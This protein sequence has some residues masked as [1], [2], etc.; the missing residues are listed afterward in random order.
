[1]NPVTE[2]ASPDME[3]LLNR[4]RP[5]VRAQHAYR[6][7]TDVTSGAKLD[8]NESP[9]GLPANVRS[10][11]LELVESIDWHRYPDDRPHRLVAALEK[12]FQLQEGSVIVGRG[13]NELTQ[14]I[15]LT[16]VTPGAKV[17][18]PDPMFALFKAVVAMHGGEAVQVPPENDL[19]HSP[20]R[21][22]QAAQEADAALVIVTTP[23]NP[24]GQTID[25]EGLKHLAGSVPGFLLIDEAY[26]EF[27]GSRPA[28]DLIASYP[29]VLVMRTFSKALGMAGLRIGY[30]AGTPQVIAEVEKARLPFLVD[31]LSEE[32]ALL[33]MDQDET[34]EERVTELGEARRSLETTIGALPGAR[35]IPG[36]ANFFLLATPIAPSALRRELAARGV[37]IRDVSSYTHLSDFVRISVGTESENR[38]LVIALQAVLRDA[39]SRPEAL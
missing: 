34:I 22:A 13:S 19:R 38:A 11:M 26:H 36:S 27:F 28:T 5:S 39:A 9:F 17:V 23:N 1:M 12:R 35:V 20:E 4:I 18:L 32:A 2:P 7:A 31:R 6:V 25:F 8:Q 15:G 29:N 14:T 30:L 21:I 33:L 10:A 3:R 24:T 37:L 16:F